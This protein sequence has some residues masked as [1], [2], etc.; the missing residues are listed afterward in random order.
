MTSIESII[1]NEKY[2]VISVKS[3][4]NYYQINTKDKVIT[5][6]NLY[7]VKQCEDV[8]KRLQQQYIR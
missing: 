6:S 2:K 1:D 4:H 7:S 5:I 3:L 8:I